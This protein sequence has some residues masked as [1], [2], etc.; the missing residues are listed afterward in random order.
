MDIINYLRYSGINVTLLLN[1]FG[2]NYKPRY[3][4]ETDPWGDNDHIFCFLFVSVRIF[5]SDGDW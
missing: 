4:K 5:I 3:T 1:P 2:W